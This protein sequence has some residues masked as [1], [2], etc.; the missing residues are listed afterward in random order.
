MV[1]RASAKVLGECVEVENSAPGSVMGQ[2]IL[3]LSMPV[4]LEYA[5]ARFLWVFA[6]MVSRRGDWERKRPRAKKQVPGISAPVRDLK[7][8]DFK[9]KGIPGI[10]K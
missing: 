3:M 6:G 2:I 7:P 5:G 10:A 4:I 8:E 9:M 1:P